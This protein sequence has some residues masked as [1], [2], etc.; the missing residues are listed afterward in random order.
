MNKTI[1][2]KPDLRDAISI[3][4]N[5][6]LPPE[7]ASESLKF[8]CPHHR[9]WVYF[10]SQEARQYLQQMQQKAEI[11]LD[12]QQYQAALPYVGCAWESAAIILALQNGDRTALIN[13]F[14]SLTV[15]L[16]IC[17]EQLGLAKYALRVRSSSVTLLSD[18]SWQ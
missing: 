14:S 13:R 6:A 4:V 16:R 2:V 7:N 17:F 10:N 15:L 11:L 9:D 12:K 1:T 5:Q 8:L 3:S 18:I